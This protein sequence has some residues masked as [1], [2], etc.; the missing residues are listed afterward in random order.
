MNRF[1]FIV[2]LNSP[3][4]AQPRI[5]TTYVG[6]GMPVSG[7]AAIDQA[8]D[9]PKSVVHKLLLWRAHIPDFARFMV[10]KQS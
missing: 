6:P 2:Q 10:T 5:I 1:M 3:G 4:F 8:I 7:G 9:Q